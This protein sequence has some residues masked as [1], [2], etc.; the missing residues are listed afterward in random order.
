MPVRFCLARDAR[1]LSLVLGLFVRALFTFQRRTA[2]RLGVPRPLTGAVAFVQRFGSALQLTPHFHLLVP[3]AVFE[4]LD[5]A[6]LR[7]HPLPRPTD[8]EVETLAVTVARR[9]LALLRARGV[10]EKEALLDGALDV[11]QLEGIQVPRYGPRP[12][13]RC[14]GRR[15]A[16]VEGFSLHADTWLHE[17]DVAGLERLCNYGARGPLSL[18]RL[19]ALPDGR[20]AYRMKRPSPTGQ[21][22]LL[23][24]PVAFLRR[25]AA[26]VPPPRA[27]LVRY[28][29]VFAPN[30]RVRPRVVPAPPPSAP[31]AEA[32]SCSL[33]PEP[34]R[35]RPPRRP[36]PWAE[37]LKRTFQTDVLACPR[38][39]GTRR[40]VAVVLRSTTA[41][42]ILEHLRLP[43]R[44]LP[45][46]PA[47]SPPQ[48][49]FW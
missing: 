43:S 35:H 11:L 46:A 4:E 8:R 15:R 5:E 21:T 17:N 2:R 18:E 10:L 49:G 47:T 12:V 34:L 36:I 32:A 44:P 39:G 6:E 7:L 42:A 27:N 33:T 3:E 24:A 9:T 26:L 13:A 40:V 22:H 31:L 14:P 20:L 19:S 28:F 45:L 23:L 30:A 29:G 25:L 16:F 41:Q 1:L 37:L 48:L 38:C